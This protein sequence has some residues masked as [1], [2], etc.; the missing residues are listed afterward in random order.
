MSLVCFVNSIS[1]MS[2]LIAFPTLWKF[3][4]CQH[5]PCILLYL[6]SLVLYHCV[7]TTFHVWGYLLDPG[8]ISGQEFIL[9]FAAIN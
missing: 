4:S 1:S 9:P 2:V 5:T 3:S 7:N 6:P 8:H